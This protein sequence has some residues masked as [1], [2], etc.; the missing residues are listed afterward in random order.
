MLKFYVT[1]QTLFIAGTDRLRDGER[2]ATATE[3]A[4][5]VAGIAV[6]VAVGVFAFGSSLNSYFGGLW[7]KVTAH[8]G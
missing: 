5:L 7:A 8:A 6:V 1:L 4:L 3:Y 2:G